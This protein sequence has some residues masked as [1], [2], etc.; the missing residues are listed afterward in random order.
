MKDEIRVSIIV[1]VYHVE[2]YVDRCINSLLSQTLKQI[3]VICVCEKED[4]SFEKLREWERKDSRV[5]LIEKMNTGVS[6]ARNVAIK[7]ARG[8]YIAF[9]DAD[10]WV[11]RYTFSSLVEIADCY[12]ADLV[13]FGLWPTLEPLGKKRAVFGL[14]PKENVLFDGGGMKALFYQHGSRPY[15]GNK[16]YRREFVENNQLLF[17]KEL[18]IG[19]DQAFQF[20]A[21]YKATRICFLKE[22][23]YHY[24]ISRNTSAMNSHEADNKLIEKNLL[25]LNKIMK[26][27][28]DHHIVD[29]DEDFVWWILHE[30]GNIY[31]NMD[32]QVRRSSAEVVLKEL[33]EFQIEKILPNLPEVYGKIYQ[34]ILAYS[35]GESEVENPV[36]GS[37]LIDDFM[38]QKTQ[39]IKTIIPVKKSLIRRCHEILAFHELR[40]FVVRVMLKIGMKQCVPGWWCKG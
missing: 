33:T 12:S 19:E 4:S 28:K 39:S 25:L 9:V 35:K 29:Y 20:E 2:E 7:S 10:D 15:I 27:R 34:V 23:F 22:K 21:F 24:D 36:Y 40:H 11:E 8:E 16:F 37:R 26:I 30:Y 32:S 1:P 3:E 6:A 14:T 31:A 17:D 13:A 5:V 38:L 18:A